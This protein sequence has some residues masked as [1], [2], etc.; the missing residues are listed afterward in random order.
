METLCVNGPRVME[1]FCEWLI[2]APVILGNK[3]ECA[4]KGTVWSGTRYHLPLSGTE[5]VHSEG[6]CFI[7]IFPRT[8]FEHSV[9]CI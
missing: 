2:V 9:P 1:T 4:V 3:R 8:L 6:F 7:E 5:D